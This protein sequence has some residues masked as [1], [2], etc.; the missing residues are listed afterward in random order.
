MR[1]FQL[2]TTMRHHFIPTRTTIIKKTML[3]VREDVKK[4][5]PSYMAGRNV[6][7]YGHLGKQPGKFLK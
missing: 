4:L 1:E 5:E 6:E 3:S 2:E 7:L